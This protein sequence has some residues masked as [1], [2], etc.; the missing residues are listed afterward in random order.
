MLIR[1][2]R[3]K[4][5][6][7][8]RQPQRIVSLVPSLT[9]TLFAFGAGERV[10]G[11]T[12]YCIHPADG[13]AAKT[14][15]GGTKNPRVERIL[16]LAPDLVLANIEENRKPDIEAL[17]AH[18]VPV[19]ATFPRTVRM[20]LDELHDLAEL[21]GVENA[22]ALIEPIERRLGS[23]EPSQRRPRVFVAVWR[24]PWMTANGDTFVG[25]LIETCG[26]ENIFRERQ[27]KFPLAAD[28]GQMPERRVEG[29]DTRYPRVSLQE[30]ASLQPEVVLLPDEPYRFTERDV[31]EVQATPGL[32]R[33]RVQLLDGTLVTWSGIRMGGALEVLPGLLRP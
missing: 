28:L 16:A 25:D 20:A 31:R 15:V 24:D 17:E 21:I 18:G 30:V 23:L 8:A 7:T 26:G 12:D 13:V 6:D 11:V 9:E 10:V 5:F 14:R 2:V 29:A 33:A 19:Y 1:D 32:E 27:R 4:S 22:P 3:G